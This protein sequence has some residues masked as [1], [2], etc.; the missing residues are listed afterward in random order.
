M[1]MEKLAWIEND[2][3][4]ILAHLEPES[5]A[6]YRFLSQRFKSHDPTND[7]LFQFVFR[8]FYRLDNA[9]LTADFKKRFFELMSVAKAEGTADIHAIS[10]ELREFPTL[11]GNNS[12]QFSFATKLAA[13]IS[14]HLPIYDSKVATI[15][16]YRTPYHRKCF[17]DRLAANLRFH[18]TLQA[19]YQRIIDENSFPTVR[20]LFRSKS[21]ASEQEITE[22]KALDFIFWTAGRS[23]LQPTKRDT[24]KTRRRASPAVV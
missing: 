15:F 8:S 11:K 1:D 4:A 19:I 24:T 6:V 23:G 7:G 2:A 5:I 12:L 9:G 17:E 18:S 20:A 10:L 14:P 21:G 13:T 22:H 3:A 16:G